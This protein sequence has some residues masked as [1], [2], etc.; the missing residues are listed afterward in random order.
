MATSYRGGSRSKGSD[1]A[2]LSLLHDSFESEMAASF[3]ADELT[4]ALSEVAAWGLRSQS[5]YQVLPPQF[6][7][8]N[9]SRAKVE[10]LEDGDSAVIGISDKGWKIYLRSVVEFDVSTSRSLCRRAGARVDLRLPSFRSDYLQRVLPRTTSHSRLWITSSPTS[11]PSLSGNG[12][13]YWRK[14]SR[15]SRCGGAGRTMRRQKR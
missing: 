11:R 10:L 14:S 13:T 12:W 3:S 4:T 9:E 15:E 1:P 8:P 5:P 6:S 7:P 2:Q